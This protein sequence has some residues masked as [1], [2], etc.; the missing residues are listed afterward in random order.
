MAAAEA[1]TIFGARVLR[2]LT[3][4]AGAQLTG[5]RVG[6]GAVASSS[7]AGILAVQAFRRYPPFSKPCPK[8][9]GLFFVYRI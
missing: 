6:Y 3:L 2:D 5:I 7:T 4:S 8:T 1:I 9:A